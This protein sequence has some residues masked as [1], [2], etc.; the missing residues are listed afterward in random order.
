MA[1]KKKL[2]YI[3]RYSLHQEFNL[4]KKFDGQLNAFSNL[5]FD[6]YYIG[7][8]EKHLYLINNGEKKILGKTHFCFP[9]YLHTLFYND[10]HKAAI[11]AI[12]VEKFDYIYWRAAPL[13]GSSC[14]VAESIKSIGAK[15]IYEIPTFPQQKEAHLNGLRKLFSVY[16]ERFSNKFNSLVDYYVLIG[17][18]AG[19]QYRGKPAI[20]IENGIDVNGVPVRTPK[21]DSEEIHLL[22]LASMSYWHGY[23]RI[24][25]SLA[26]YKEDRKVIIHMVGGNDGGCLEEWRELSKKLGV[27]ENVIFHGPLSGAQLDEMFDLCDLGVNSLAMYR[28]DFAVTMELK[29]REYIARGLPFV[30]AVE[31]PGFADIKDA[32]WLRIPNDDSI[33]NMQEIIDF[34]LKMKHDSLHTEKLRVLAQSRLTWE[35]QHKKI[36]DIVGGNGI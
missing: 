18:D 9:S 7:F 4:K 12:K 15:L 27:S 36:F 26:Q 31:D 11:K 34:T 10:L 1:N 35:E 32:M 28:K 14:K 21:N 22:A 8:D 24:I 2:L 6:V 20:N 23:D 33:P 16:S 13:W 17:E 30:C 29:A 3:T 5:G 25:N 19:G